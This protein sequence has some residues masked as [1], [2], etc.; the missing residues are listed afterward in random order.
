MSDIREIRSHI[1]SIRDTEKIT[2]AMY[3]IASTK[4]NKAK[5]ELN[6]TR[7]YFEFIQSEI[8]RVFKVNKEISSRYYY[9]LDSDTA[10]TG[11]NAYLIVTADR[12]LA[13]SY[14]SE[15]IRKAEEMIAEHGEGRRFVIGEFGRKYYTTKN[16]P[17]EK[18]FH[19]TAQNPTLS[20]ARDITSILLE[21]YQNEEIGKIYIIYTDMKKNEEHEARVFRLLPFHRADLDTTNSSAPSTPFHF[22]PSIKDVL[23]NMVSSYMSGF[24]YSAL[25]VSYCCELSSR[26]NAMDL[27]SQNAEEILSGLIRA[28][29][30][31]RQNKVTQE[32]T[33][34]TSG[35]RALKKK[36]EKALK[37]NGGL[38]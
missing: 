34:I 10:I 15:V 13:G 33:E 11:E 16:I 17:F 29:N 23:Y 36:K 20:R 38:Q 32:I 2:N 35:A 27:A 21:K 22:F 6:R 8:K 25:I 5:L 1:K 4:M 19:Y 28:Y 12:G 31:A 3:M 26:M 14:N 9:P 24:I 18:D 7:P 37:Q 30:H